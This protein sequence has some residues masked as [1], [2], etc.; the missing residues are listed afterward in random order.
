MNDRLLSGAKQ[1][2]VYLC[3]SVCVCLSVGEKQETKIDRTAGRKRQ[4]D[5]GWKHK[6]GCRNDHMTLW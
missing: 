3:V 4:G 1:K 5:D 2:N 6:H